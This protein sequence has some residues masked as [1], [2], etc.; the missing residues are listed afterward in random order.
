MASTFDSIPPVPN[1]YKRQ[2][3]KDHDVFCIQRSNS[4]NNS[5]IWIP[6]K[7]LLANG[8]LDGINFTHSFGRRN[9][10]GYCIVNTKEAVIRQN[11]AFVEQAS[12]V[13]KYGGFFVSRN[14]FLYGKNP[15]IASWYD[16]Q[17][18]AEEFS[19]YYDYKVSSHLV[20]GSEYDSIIQWIIQSKTFDMSFFWGPYSEWTQEVSI[21]EMYAVIR[22]GFQRVLL[23]R[24][25]RYN[26]VGF[27]IAL[28]IY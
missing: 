11:I 13:E 9:F 1:G 21:D 25:N 4:P 16:A 3:L 18:L 7:D 17:C 20:F 27:R 6:V 19:S 5:F 28:T 8:T 2:S 10:G 14:L 12:S 26:R 24:T 15:K 23:R 22:Y